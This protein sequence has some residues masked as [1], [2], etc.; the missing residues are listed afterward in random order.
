MSTARALTPPDA[1]GPGAGRCGWTSPTSGGA[2]DRDADVRRGGR[3]LRLL[4][5]RAGGVS[6]QASGLVALLMP[7]SDTTCRGHGWVG[8]VRVSRKGRGFVTR[9]RYE[10]C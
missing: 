2:G 5:Y 4:R 1:T 9:F 7:D 8:T 10:T 6:T 3:R